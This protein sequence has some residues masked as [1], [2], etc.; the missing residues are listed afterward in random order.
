MTMVPSRISSRP[1]PRSMPS[2]TTN[3]NNE[4]PHQSL[5]MATSDG[6][7]FIRLGGEAVLMPEPLGSLVRELPWRRQV[8]ISGKASHRSRFFPGGRLDDISTPPTFGCVSTRSKSN[9][10][11]P[12]D[13]L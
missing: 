5:G 8:G 4:R 1:K 2:C 13:A 11:L 12:D 7:T 10:D 3:Y 9:V 6:S